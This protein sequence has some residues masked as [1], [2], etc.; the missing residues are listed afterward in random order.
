[1][2]AQ[3]LYR[4]SPILD[5]DGIRLIQLQP[6]TS[7][8]SIIRCKLI[9]TRLRTF[10]QD[11][12]EHY[13]A[14][15][16]VWGDAAERT[17][18][19]VGENTLEITK[20]LDSALKHLRDET[21][22]LNVWADG[23]C[24]N[25]ND[26]LEKG[27]QVQQM[28]KIYETADHTVIFLGE[29]DIKTEQTLSCLANRDQDS[30]LLFDTK[31]ND[32]NRRIIQELLRR[33]WFTRVWVYQELVMSRDPWIQ[34][35]RVRCL[36]S[37]FCQ[38]TSRCFGPAKKNVQRS[39]DSY[40]LGYS[41]SGKIVRQ[42]EQ[43]RSDFLGARPTPKDVLDKFRQYK[44]DAEM[45][46]IS[47]HQRDMIW[48]KRDGYT[49]LLE[50]LVSRKGFGAS[51]PRDLVFSI[52]GLCRDVDIRADYETTTSELYQAVAESHMELHWSLEI[53]SY[54]EDVDFSLRM[55]GLASWAPNWTVA[56]QPR[57]HIRIMSESS[58]YTY[59]TII[60]QSKEHDEI[61][62]PF[63][64]IQSATQHNLLC[65]KAYETS[66]IR[67]LSSTIDNS[68]NEGLFN[69][70]A[71]QA[72]RNANRIELLAHSPYSK[73]AW[74]EAY[75][76]WWRTWLG[77]GQLILPPERSLYATPSSINSNILPAAG[78]LSLSY[79]SQP[80]EPPV[81]ASEINSG[82]RE[83]RLMAFLVLS[84]N[85]LRR[86]AF[87]TVGNWPAWTMFNWR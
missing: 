82:Q 6:S 11:F 32:E 87:L 46:S 63:Y 64:V 51:D 68:A 55:P 53:L 44:Y 60:S 58:D 52:L 21:R 86:Q 69:P 75:Y 76:D 50:I 12:F 24:I 47:K 49:K 73:A 36:W 7:R 61:S 70:H 20:N 14:L 34:Y 72:S 78:L 27:T 67:H 3:M 23:V 42:M 41:S 31:K 2:D 37:L 74:D 66:R 22:V 45:A 29:C 8:E 40:G 30:S 85:R 56:D 25:Q 81:D 28:G 83:S 17:Q 26:Y 71:A 77:P 54:V 59:G 57:R 39:E 65:C 79:V 33:P 1:M 19:I 80:C 18:I 15:S 4:Y 48:T 84:Y 5:N 43:S 13:T 62:R 38:F 9:H 35:G 10:R 16:Y